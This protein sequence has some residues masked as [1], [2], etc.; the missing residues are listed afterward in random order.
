MQTDRTRGW[1]KQAEAGAAVASSISAKPQGIWPR[2]C[3]IY[4]KKESTGMARAGATRQR[5]V[6]ASPVTAGIKL[7]LLLLL[8]LNRA[9]RVYNSK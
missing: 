1:A 9:S 2:R 5:V 6:L 7:L 3:G 8:P 4:T